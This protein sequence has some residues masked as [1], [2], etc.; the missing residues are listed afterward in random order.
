VPFM[1]RFPAFSVNHREV[2]VDYAP[3]KIYAVKEPLTRM[4]H[5][6]LNGVGPQQMYEAFRAERRVRRVGWYQWAFGLSN[7]P[8]IL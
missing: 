7:T 2:I 5:P 3:V 4:T 8:S 1:E 6:I